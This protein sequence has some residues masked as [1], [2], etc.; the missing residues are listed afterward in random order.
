MAEF[1]AQCVA[2]IRAE[3]E[4]VEFLSLEE[5]R[6][7][8]K[9]RERLE[10]R[11]RK[12]K[13]QEK[14]F[15]L[16]IQYEK[17]V[18]LYFKQRKKMMGVKSR[19]EVPVIKRIHQLYQLCETRFPQSTDVWLQ[20]I[21]FCQKQKEYSRV[22]RLFTQMLRTHSNQP[23][24]WVKAAR[25]EVEQSNIDDAR[26]L[27]QR[28]VSTNKT[29]IFAWVQFY[30]LELEIAKSLRVQNE[31]ADDSD[32]QL[33]RL[34]QLVSQHACLQCPE[35]FELLISL[36]EVSEKFN[37][38]HSHCVE[39][40]Q[41][42]R[43]T[44]PLVPRVWDFLAR[45]SLPS[46]KK[47]L[48]RLSE[49][50]EECF[51][52]LYEE[53][54]AKIPTMEMWTLYIEGGLELMAVATTESDRLH[55]RMERVL[56][57]FQRAADHS[58]LSVDMFSHW[59]SLQRQGGEGDKVRETC[60]LMAQRFPHSVEAWCQCLNQHFTSLSPPDLVVACLNRAL[61]AL[62][63]KETWS[64]W[65]PALLYLSAANYQHLWS[66]MEKP[67]ISL[68]QE[69]GVPAR[70]F[71]LRWTSVNK[72]MQATRDVFSKLSQY[73]PGSL[74]LCLEYV[75]QEL[76]Q[77]KVKIKKIRKAFENAITEF[78]KISPDLWLRYM[79]VEGNHGD[80]LQVSSLG[81]RAMLQLPPGPLQDTFCRLRAG[82]P[83][84]PEC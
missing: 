22:G 60:E 36:I 65:E 56:G 2:Q 29:D 67:C 24:L 41:Q 53:A 14:D 62:P 76:M 5:K 80:P 37:F 82:L 61:V 78:G 51:F 71:C 47:K 27:M 59:I 25:W 42:L 81:S 66:L 48:M 20:H 8:L 7:I 39:M 69:L 13:R 40:L 19:A 17:D 34:A 23:E 30:K 45:R 46:T 58:C 32:P 57:L 28:C 83:Q 12:R 10:Y 6:K 3:L 49:W 75:R 73:K 4:S 84:A 33:G 63:E 26:T 79:E 21:E 38:T 35:S 64:V 55:K 68:C 31:T 54:V 50:Q 77:E 1:V 18:L 52:S 9:K 72:D 43:E 74:D 44:F 16:Y 70:V 15:L 11:I